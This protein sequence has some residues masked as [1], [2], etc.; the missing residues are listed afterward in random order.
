[1]QSLVKA[2]V[3]VGA[4]GRTFRSQSDGQESRAFQPFQMRS[5][6]IACL[7]NVEKPQSKESHGI[8][9]EGLRSRS[10]MHLDHNRMAGI[11]SRR[12][13]CRSASRA[14]NHACD[15]TWDRAW[16][17]VARDYTTSMPL[18]CPDRHSMDGFHLRML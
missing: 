5:F 8:A 4:R 17:S 3:A 18:V 15:P 13:N 14:S 11:A 12:L 6:Q 9:D 10:I 16:S 7:V 2:D 1:M